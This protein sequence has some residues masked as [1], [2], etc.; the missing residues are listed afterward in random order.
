VLRPSAVA[1]RFEALR[2][3]ALSPVVGRDEEIELLLRRW[4]RAKA[5]DGQIVLVSG[6]AS[7]GKSR[8]VAALAERLHTAPY[9][10][11]RYFCSPYHQD[12]ALFPFIDQLGRAS[13]FALDDPPAA[14]REKLEAVLAIAS[15]PD[16][17][18]AFLTD[19]LS[20]PASE[21]HPLPD[22]SVNDN[23]VRFFEARFQQTLPGPPTAVRII[24]FRLAWQY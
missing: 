16:E 5:G 2:G 4:A 10:R 11:L 12:S 20:L 19:L 3:A 13:G 22:L 17:D 23:I 1:S 18:V 15:P 24:V 9:L 21:R 8:I 7:L 14:R 6:E